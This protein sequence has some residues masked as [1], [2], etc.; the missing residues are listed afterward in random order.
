MDYQ[1]LKEAND[2][3]AFEEFKKDADKGHLF[4][5]YEVAMMYENGI[6]TVKNSEKAFEYYEKASNQGHV[7][8]QIYLGGMY[9]HG[10]GKAKNLKKAF[11]YYEKAADNSLNSLF[12]FN[13]LSLQIYPAQGNT[14]AQHHLG[15][16]YQFGIG[17]V[18][19]LKKAFE[20]YEKA[21]NQGYAH[22]QYNLGIMYYGGT[23]TSKNLEKAFE[24]YEK[25]ANQGHAHSQ[26]RLGYMYQFGIGKEKNL[27]KS[28]EYYE[29]AANQGEYFSIFEKY[30]SSKCKKVDHSTA[31]ITQ[32]IQPIPVKRPF[33]LDMSESSVCSSAKKQIIIID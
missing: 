20:Y 22:S 6:G 12:E 32:P 15:Y 3:F 8:S 17:T 27:E 11:E 33:I 13:K 4:C 16:M 21:A 26:N 30:S 5:Q 29:K 9:E 18:K 31:Q 19:N 23:G 10:I 24:Y 25:A 7:I 14:Q 2:K 28:L 1:K